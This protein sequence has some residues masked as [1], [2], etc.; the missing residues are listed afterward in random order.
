M[1]PSLHI[2]DADES[3]LVKVC[4]HLRRRVGHAPIPKFEDFV[5]CRPRFRL[6][7]DDFANR[8]GAH[9]D[10]LDIV[11]NYCVVNNLQF[12]DI[13][14]ASR[15][16]IV[17]GTVGDFNKLFNIKAQNYQLK[18]GVF[19]YHDAI[20]VPNNVAPVLMDVTGIWNELPMRIMAGE[21]TNT[22]ALFPQTIKLLYQYQN[23]PTSNPTQVVGILMSSGYLTSDITATFNNWGLTAPTILN[24]K[25]DSTAIS[26]GAGPA[27]L[28]DTGDICCFSSFSPGATIQYYTYDPKISGD[29]TTYI[30][31]MLHPRAGE[32]P[33][34]VLSFSFTY[35]NQSNAHPYFEGNS[36]FEAIFQDCAMQGVSIFSGTGDEG[37]SGYATDG[38]ACATYP[39][40]SPWVC[41]VGGTVIG[42]ITGTAGTPSGNFY[43]W[44]YNDDTTP[45]SVT[46]GGVSQTY[47][48]PSYQSSTSIPL[49]ITANTAGR[50]VPDVAANSSTVS[51]IPVYVNGVKTG[52]DGTSM[53]TPIMAGMIATINTFLG[54]NVG[55]INSTLYNVGS[56]SLANSGIISTAG[57]TFTDIHGNVWSLETSSGSGLQIY[58]NN[59]L[60]AT[61]SNVTYFVYFNPTDTFYQQ[62]SA[63]SWYYKI[64]PTGTWTQATGINPLSNLV[65]I[66]DINNATG[67]AGNNKDS[68]YT[69]P[70]YPV[71]IG[72]DCCTGLG[73]P[74]VLPFAYFIKNYNESLFTG[75]NLI[76]YYINVQA[77]NS[78]GN[79]VTSTVFGP[80][81]VTTT[82]SPVF[83]QLISTT[84]STMT[85]GWN[86]PSLITF[87]SH[88]VYYTP[89][90]GSLTSAT[91]TPSQVSSVA[92]NATITGLSVHGTYTISVASLAAGAW[93]PYTSVNLTF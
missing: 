27:T 49:H 84:S 16:V 72:Y 74:N 34:T 83:L 41:A 6:S 54:Y 10:D 21:P 76:N 2:G 61:S 67:G 56:G 70:G 1:S 39:A 65:C 18:N 52:M 19:R 92:W 78:V 44:V 15:Q 58:E 3:Q 91:V 37:S 45:H 59:V 57:P 32:N 25:I 71:Q 20:A 87:T 35:A 50:G 29:I 80:L 85:I 88:S 64:T 89:P 48:V 9:D 90:G 26:G 40:T 81:S 43:E 17:K 38:S 12:V 30:P 86:L 73:V 53:G 13:H 93:S 69:S 75:N 14:P 23:M 33:V 28:E 68:G 5:G 77:Q 4:F 46:G 60:D 36:T 11:K 82:P 47:P 55:F 62:N 42:N 24:I 63:G 66:R 79:G 31:R 51:N 22:V 7:E 8:Y